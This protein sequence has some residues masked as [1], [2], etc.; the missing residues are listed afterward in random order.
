MCVVSGPAQAG[1]THGLSRMMGNYQVR[2][3]GEGGGSDAAS[4]PDDAGKPVAGVVLLLDL[5]LAVDGSP[6]PATSIGVLVLDFRRVA[7]E[8]SRSGCEGERWI[9]RLLFE[10]SWA[11]GVQRGV[12]PR[13][14]VAEQPFERSV[15]RVPVF[16]NSMSCN[17]STFKEPNRVSEHPSPPKP[18]VASANSTPSN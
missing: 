4:L 12:H 8:P 14:V 1:L 18:F 17:R 3:L 10:L 13:S 5:S 11:E 15:L 6:I 7:V 16:W 2:F 9:D